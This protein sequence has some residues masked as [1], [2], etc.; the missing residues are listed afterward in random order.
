MVGGEGKPGIGSLS[1]KAL[2]CAKII[3]M[4]VVAHREHTS[5]PPDKDLRTN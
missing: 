4:K 2:I 3:C 1:R 5:I